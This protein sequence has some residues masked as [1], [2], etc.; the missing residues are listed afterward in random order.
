MYTPWRAFHAEPVGFSPDKLSRQCAM[1]GL[2]QGRRALSRLT[3]QLPEG[4]APMKIS[5]WLCAI[6]FTDSGI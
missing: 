1:A 2:P 3:D 6:T 4:L 5:L